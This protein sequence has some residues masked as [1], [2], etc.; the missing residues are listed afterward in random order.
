MARAG[1]AAAQSF[2]KPTLFDIPISNHGARVSAGG[3][4][5]PPTARCK[6]AVIEQLQL[7]GSSASRQ[8]SGAWCAVPLH[9]LQEGVGGRDR[10]QVAQGA[11]RP[12]VRQLQGAQP[13]RQDAAA[14]AARRHRPARERGARAPA[15]PPA[16]RASGRATLTHSYGGGSSGATLLAPHSGNYARTSSG[17]PR[18]PCGA[19]GP[20]RRPPRRARLSRSTWWRS[21]R[22]AG[23]TCCRPSRSLPRACGS[24]PVSTTCTYRPSRRAVSARPNQPRMKPLLC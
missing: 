6:C 7:A 16:R 5:M 22:D 23:P 10:H 21:T 24:S 18:L 15:G 20:R 2:S 3:L 11:G 13:A 9:H 19:L 1:P 4:A 17:A 8:G 12:D 14:G